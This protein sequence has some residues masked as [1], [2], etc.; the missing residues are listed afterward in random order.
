MYGFFDR[1]QRTLVVNWS[2]GAGTLL[3]ELTHALFDADRAELPLWFHEG[4]AS[5]HEE[6]SLYSD[7]DRFWLEPRD[8]WRLDT[9]RDSMAETPDLSISH[10]LRYADFRGR[11]EAQDYAF[12]RYLCLYL[13]QS[14]QLARYYARWR[15]QMDTDPLGLVTLSTF[16]PG[17]DWDHKNEAFRQWVVQRPHELGFTPQ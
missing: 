10:Q 5:L 1:S 16:L 12:A 14:G 6:A 8:N 4:M 2:A 11:S 15:P 17:A 13:H 7:Q 9:L 3:H